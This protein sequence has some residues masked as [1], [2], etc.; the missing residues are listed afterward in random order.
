MGVAEPQSLER[1]MVGG[2]QRPQWRESRE[3]PKFPKVRKVGRISF[4]PEK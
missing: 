1:V 2:K 4:L 3:N